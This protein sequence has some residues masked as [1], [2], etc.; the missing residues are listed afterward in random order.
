[1]KFS[2][3]LNTDT[4]M[5]KIWPFYED[6]NKWF[7]W[8][9]DLEDI[10]LNGE[11]TQNTTGSMTLSGQPSMEFT[12]VSVVPGKSFT[13]KTSIPDIGDI[14]FIHELNKNEQQTFIKHS[15]E[16]IPFNRK[17]TVKDLEFISQI[18]A[19]VPSSVFSLIEAANG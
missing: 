13:D 11:F 4:P 3:E 1:M 8:E 7:S 9:D 2:F 19:D 15:V 6:I 10:S 14:Y 18:F 17:T 16:F 5:E 12:L